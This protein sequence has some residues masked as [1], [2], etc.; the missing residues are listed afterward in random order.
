[1]P[2]SRLQRSAESSTSTA[3]GTSTEVTTETGPDNSVLANLLNGSTKLD[4]TAQ[5]WFD[6]GITIQRGMKGKVVEEMQKLI[7]T[8]ADGDYGPGTERAVKR[9]QKKNGKAET[10][11]VDGVQWD[12]M[13]MNSKSFS[14]P[15]GDAAFDE[16]WEA[17][18]HNYLQDSSQNTDSGDLNEELGYERDQWGNTCAVRM[19]T[20]LNRM[21]GEYA[22]TP[23][24]AIAAGLGK[25]RDGGLYLPKAKDPKTESTSDRII[26]SA[27]EMIAYL[28]HHMGEPDR[29]FPEE[30]RNIMR[31]D[32]EAATPDVEGALAGR[33]GFICF[34]KMKLKDADGSWSGYGGSGHVDIF[35]GKQLSDGDVYAAQRVLIWY[36]K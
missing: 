35:D 24:K 33:K 19:S 5:E 18:P 6:Q 1:M 28:D 21:G 30:G 12:L 8:G 7:G 34:D 11:H 15:Q 26:V 14:K 13:K 10:G 31:K 23:E 4:G 32:A 22:I 29:V 20:M 25:M 16:M 17:H 27:R 3:T 9:W 36:V 2:Q